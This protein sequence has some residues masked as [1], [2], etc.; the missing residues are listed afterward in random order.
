VY[1]AELADILLGLHLIK[2]EKRNKVGCVLNVDNQAALTAINSSM[3]KLGQ[4]LAAVVH[5]MA[6]KLQP[7]GNGSRFSLTFRWS[8]GHIGIEGNEI[9]DEEVKST[10]EGESSARK[11]LPAY[12]HKPVKC[13]LTATRQ[14]HNEVLKKKWTNAWTFSPRY[15]KARFQDTLTPASQN[16]LKY[17][18]SQNI[19]RAAA[20][21]LFQLRVGHVPLNQYLYRF[22]RVDN[23]RCP[24]CGHPKETAEHFLIYCPKYAHERWPLLR[25]LGNTPPKIIKLLTNKK[26]L[27]PLINYIEATERFQHTSGPDR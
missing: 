16:Y 17:I 13:S 14:S 18:C 3:T 15:L 24:A 27:A 23:P 20:S 8:A 11:D 6:K 7:K 25:R 21:R 2:T 4:H 10:A 9:A 19:S 5:T 22:K 1:E 26:L 12:L